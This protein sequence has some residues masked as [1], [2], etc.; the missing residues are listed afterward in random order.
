VVTVFV[1]KAGVLG[2]NIDIITDVNSQINTE[3][4]F[5]LW[6]SDQNK[7][8]INFLDDHPMKIPTYFVSAGPVVS[9]KIKM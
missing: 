4:L 2:R 1:V 9:E 3:E 6:I 8:K 5:F 7:N